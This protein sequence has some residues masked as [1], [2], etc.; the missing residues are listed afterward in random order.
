MIIAQVY[1][2]VLPEHVDAFLAATLDNARNSVQEPGVIRFDVVRQAD[3]PTRFSLIE[4][5]RDAQAP[6][7][8]KETA[9][10][11]RWRDTVAPMMASPRTSVRYEAVF[12]AQAS[13]EMPGG[14]TAALAD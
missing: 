7:A 5:Y 11:A 4:I 10:Y 2:H 9:H 13:W 14:S 12:P 6:I 3:D 8:H 1:I